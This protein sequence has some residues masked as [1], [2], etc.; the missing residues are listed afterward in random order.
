MMVRGYDRHSHV[1]PYVR[2]YI[3][4][5]P[6]AVPGAKSLKKISTLSDKR[7]ETVLRKPV[8]LNIPLL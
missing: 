4:E 7:H 8:N 5:T 6:S 3:S 1:C 2:L